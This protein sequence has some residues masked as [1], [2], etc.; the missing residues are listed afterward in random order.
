MAGFLYAASC[1]VGLSEAV[2]AWDALIGTLTEKQKETLWS[3]ILSFLIKKRSNGAILWRE[4]SSQRDGDLPYGL[5]QRSD[6]PSHD[7]ML[8]AAC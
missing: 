5:S 3:D 7:G 1:T 2:K 4:L 6:S 8:S